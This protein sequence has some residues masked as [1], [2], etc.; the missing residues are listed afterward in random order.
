MLDVIA[1]APLVVPARRVRRCRRSIGWNNQGSVNP[2]PVGAGI[3]AAAQIG[4]A[5]GV[6]WVSFGWGPTTVYRPDGSDVSIP[7]AGSMVNIQPPAPTC[8]SVAGGALGSRTYWVYTAYSR[9]GAVYLLSN[10]TQITVPANQLLKV[11]SPAAKPGY[12]GYVVYMSDVNGATN[13][14]AQI[15]PFPFGTDWTEPTSGIQTA[16]WQAAIY[17]SVNGQFWAYLTVPHLNASTSYYFY[18]YWDL[19]SNQMVMGNGYRGRTTTPGVTSYDPASA[20]EQNGDGHIPLMGAGGTNASGAIL[21]A[22]SGVGSGNASA[23]GGGVL[24]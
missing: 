3:F 15:D 24:T 5:G 20:A 9:N 16:S 4:L 14:W 8:S 18:P 12:D 19:A 10:G 13:P 7:T 21:V 23:V 17:T 6:S 22:T 1:P 2:S 11:T